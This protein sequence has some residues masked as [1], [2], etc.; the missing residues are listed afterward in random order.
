M[1]PGDLSKAQHIDRMI[2]VD[3]AGEYGAQRIYAGQLAVLKHDA[4]AP[5]IAHM[6]AQEQVH[7][8]RF[9]HLM[10]ER[11]A[12][13]SALIPFWHVAGYALGAGTALLGPKAAMA[14]TVA[15]ESV[16]AEHYQQQLENMP[17]DEPELRDTITQFRAEEMEHHDIG[18]AHDAES[19]PAY[20]LLSGII[21]RGCR[22]A[23]W[24]AERV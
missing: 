3:H 19:A 2:R 17:E 7:L 22:A 13:P 15:V 23:I 16:I 1:I 6:A 10:T 9:N 11:R 12:R 8:A 24:I 18:I 20:E 14:C 4:T 5:E 21:K